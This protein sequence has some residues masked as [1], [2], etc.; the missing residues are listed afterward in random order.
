[1]VDDR[2]DRPLDVVVLGSTNLDLTLTVEALPAPG[3]T[4]LGGDPVRRAGGK[5]GN[6]AVAAARA[7]ARTAFLGCVGNDPEGTVLIDDLAAYGI[8]VTG[9]RTVAD[10]SGLA[11]ILVNSDGENQIAVAAGANFRLQADDVDAW[12]PVISAARVLVLQLEI[13][14]AVVE[15]AVAIAADAGTMVMLNLS[16]AMAVAAG[17]LARVDVLVVNRTEADFAAGRP[18]GTEPAELAAA[19]RTLGPTAVVVTA[20]ADGAICTDASATAHVPAL[21]VPVRDTTGAGDAFAGT[22]AARLATGASLAD[23]GRAAAVAAAQTV[24]HVGARPPTT[25]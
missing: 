2:G 15:R 1:M 7:G 21:R 25:D 19:L 3:D 5:G 6:Q 4:V 9:V 24:Q 17:T 16:P 23:A 22:L 8:D 18:A 20:G 12:R 13:P 10:P 11:V 14:P